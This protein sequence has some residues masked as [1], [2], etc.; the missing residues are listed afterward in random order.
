MK[1]NIDVLKHMKEDTIDIE[2]FVEGI[3]RI[4]Y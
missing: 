1:K 4:S 2:A 3:W